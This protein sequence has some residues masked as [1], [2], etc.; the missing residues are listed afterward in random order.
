MM[1]EADS[2]LTQLSLFG[3]CELQQ[4]GYTQDSLSGKMFQVLSPATTDLTFEQSLNTSQRAKFQYLG[5]EDGQTQDWFNAERVTLHGASLMLNIGECPN[6]ERESSL[7][8]ILEQLGDVPTRYYLSRKSCLS[9]LRR[10]RRRKKELPLELRR[11]LVCQ[12]R[13]GLTPMQV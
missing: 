9:I 13:W 11:A 1:S 10:A 3:K 2:S 7:S 5:M 12:A 8:L 4:M 6:D